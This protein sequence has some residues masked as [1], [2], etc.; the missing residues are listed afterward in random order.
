MLEKIKH[1]FSKMF[2]GSIPN[3]YSLISENNILGI[4]D[5]NFLITKDENFVTGLTID[6]I[7]YLSLNSNM[8]LDSLENRINMLNTIGDNIEIRVVVKRRKVVIDKE[9]D[10]IKNRY[11]REI[12]NT[13]E[14]KATV[15]ENKYLII[16]ETK[17]EKMTSYLEEKKIRATTTEGEN[18]KNLTHSNKIIS[19]TQAVERLIHTLSNEGI[20][21][22]SSLEL[23]RQYGEYI[24]GTY[25]PFNISQGVLSDNYIASNIY[26]K[27]DYFIQ[28]Y[29]GELKYNRFISIK[30][31]DTEEI[32]SIPISNI[33]HLETECDIILSVDSL[34]KEKAIKKLESKKKYAI[35]LIKGEIDELIELVKSDRTL[36]QYISL[37]ILISNNNLE[38]MKKKSSEILN[39][40]KNNGIVAV[41][42]TINLMPLYFSFFP[43]R[44]NL[45]A[46]KRLQSSKNISTMIL[47]EKEGR[48]YTRNS[49]GNH[50]LTV[51][52]SQSLSNY[53]FNFHG[54]EVKRDEL[55]LGH[56][57][58]IGGSGTGK[59]TLIEF[60]ITNCFKYDINIL[61]LDRLNGMKVMT[62]FLDG[63]YNDGEEGHF[64]INP[65]SLD[66]STE[67]ISF[68]SSWLAFLCRLTDD[69][70]EDA[71]YFKRIEDSIKETYRF[72]TLQKKE[73]GIKEVYENLLKNEENSTEESPIK[74]QIGREL[75]NSIFTGIKD[76]LG[77]DKQLTTINMD[78]IMNNATHASLV[79]LYLFHKIIYKAKN[80]NKGFF[81]FIDEANSYTKNEEML[82]KI[83]LT[84]TQAR[85]LNGVLCLAFQD[86]NQ[87][88]DV[89]GAKSLIANMAHIILYPNRDIERLEEMNISLTDHEKEFLVNSK[90]RDRKILL[91]NIKDNTSIILD[92][93]LGKL[94]KYLKTFS[95]SANDVAKLKKYKL[96]NPN[97]ISYKERFLCDK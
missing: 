83:I 90:P 71:K 62:D 38:N 97:P 32:S 65:F 21:K 12:I 43:G 61:A 91:K 66:G 88:D 47:F 84:L 7:N 1:L 68:L 74:I 40:F 4:Y 78:F 9:Y 51:F 24:N 14:K 96:E 5:Y 46:R 19:L 93:D 15:F 22:I 16:L 6:G 56:T 82:K 17:K 53:L 28:E 23:L 64:N 81:I 27:K 52:K 31:Y 39:I 3:N 54:E 92:V 57:I 11:A 67:N 60:L 70:M 95:S 86:I 2:V 33:L 37:T 35:N 77:F 36:I 10:Y 41:T 20:R 63:E 29:D 72:L 50:P 30:N 48:G 26:F 45:N 69:K 76:S 34:P 73:F 85:K 13:W 8:I 80:E 87:L 79:A 75:S 94:G 58:I 44:G 18:K 59:T 55:V 42:E 49:W 89:Q 25:I